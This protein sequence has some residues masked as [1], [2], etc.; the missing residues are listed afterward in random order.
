[1]SEEEFNKALKALTNGECFGTDFYN[2]YWREIDERLNRVREA[3]TDCKRLSVVFRK[4]RSGVK[5]R[6]T[7]PSGCRQI[8]IPTNEVFWVIDSFRKRI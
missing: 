2:E 5:C 6:F 7:G 4:D 8:S 1:M 3:L